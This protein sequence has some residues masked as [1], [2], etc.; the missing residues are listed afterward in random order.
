MGT[1]REG[2]GRASLVLLFDMRSKYRKRETDLRVQKDFPGAPATPSLIRGGTL[3]WS[4]ATP[5]RPAICAGVC[6]CCSGLPGA[7]SGPVPWTGRALALPW[8]GITQFAST[9]KARR[10]F[11]SSARGGSWQSCLGSSLTCS[12]SQRDQKMPCACR[13]K[14]HVETSPLLE[15]I[16]RRQQEQPGLMHNFQS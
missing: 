14:W 6:F 12:I 15:Y 5:A 4:S 1:A 10:L 16:P 7:S 13:D 11:H 8:K 2:P 9:Q 3:L